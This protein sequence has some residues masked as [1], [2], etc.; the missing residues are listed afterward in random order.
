[1]SMSERSRDA[2]QVTRHNRRQ[3][4]ELATLRERGYSPLA[5]NWR[6]RIRGSRRS[7]VKPVGAEPRPLFLDGDGQVADAAS[8]RSAEESA[9]PISRPGAA[10]SPDNGKMRGHEYAGKNILVFPDIVLPPPPEPPARGPL[11]W[12]YWSARRK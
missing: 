9:S 10:G 1:M 2:H 7:P 4:E 5:A 12:A 11:S 8:R 6:T 3:D